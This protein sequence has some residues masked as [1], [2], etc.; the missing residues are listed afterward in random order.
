MARLL[1]IIERYWSTHF[2]HFSVGD[3][4]DSLT[5]QQ[6]RAVLAEAS[7]KLLTLGQ[8]RQCAC[9]T[10]GRDGSVI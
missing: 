6:V 2:N 7:T 3:E 8:L 10:A 5:I 9:L 1:A 4:I